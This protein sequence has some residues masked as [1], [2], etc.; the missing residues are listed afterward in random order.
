ML[1]IIIFISMP[2]MS[3]P[4]IGVPCWA[5]ALPVMKMEAA[6]ARNMRFIVAPI[7]FEGL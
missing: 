7:F 3:I 5:N 2:F 6:A 1:G 4:G